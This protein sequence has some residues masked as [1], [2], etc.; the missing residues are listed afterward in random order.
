M[1]YRRIYYFIYDLCYRRMVLLAI[2]M[3][4][5]GVTYTTRLHATRLITTLDQSSRKP[6]RKPIRSFP[7]TNRLD[8]AI[9][10]LLL[11]HGLLPLFVVHLAHVAHGEDASLHLERVHLERLV[12][13]QHAED[14]VPAWVS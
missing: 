11:V 9:I 1:C 4:R 2:R 12:H 10:V 7:P 5:R 6:N 13:V 14:L 3:A 8:C